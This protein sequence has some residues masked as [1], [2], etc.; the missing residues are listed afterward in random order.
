LTCF[1]R[2]GDGAAI[3]LTITFPHSRSFANRRF[4]FTGQFSA[5]GQQ[6]QGHWTYACQDCTCA[7][8]GGALTLERKEA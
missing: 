6:I 4:E 3:S 2:D 5:D 8:A 1:A 7:G